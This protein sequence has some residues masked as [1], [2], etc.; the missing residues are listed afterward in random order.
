MLKLLHYLKPYFWQTILLLVV[1]VIRTWSALQLPALMADI[2]NH[3]IVQHDLT[4]VRQT[5]LLMLVYAALTAASGFGSSFL[6][7]RIGTSFARDLRADLFQKVLNLGIGEIEKFSTASLITRT[8]NDINQIQQAVIM[9][10]SLMLRVPLTCVIAVGLAVATAPSMTWIIALAVAIVVTIVICIFIVVGPKFKTLQKLVDKITLLTR[11]NLTGLRVVRA[12]NNQRLEK[13]KFDDANRE[14]TRTNIFVNK[15]LY[16]MNPMMAFM[17][18]AIQ[19]VMSFLM[20]SMLLIILPR[21]N[22]SAQRLNEVLHARPQIRWPRRTAGVPAKRPSVEFRKVSFAY[23]AAEAKV[24]HEISFVAQAGQTTARI[25]S[26]GSGKSTVINLVPRFL[27]V[28]SGEILVNG[29]NVKDYTE[30]DLMARIGYVP[31]RGKL[32]SGTIRE[33]IQFGAPG[34]TQQQVKLAAE[35]SQS[36]EFIQKLP[37]GYDARVASGGNNLSGGQ[38]QRLAIARAIAK[39]PDIYIF[40]DAFSAL[41]LKTDQKLRAAL[42]EVTADAVVLVVAQRISTIKHAEQIVVLDHGRVVG[43]GTH[44]ELLAGCQVYQEIARSQLSEAEY[45]AELKLSRKR[46]GGKEQKR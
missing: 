27:E 45:A 35:I 34:A 5:S 32:F 37:G 26:T 43:K 25:G 42:A 29:L 9:C 12:F 19:V 14:L 16:L 17:Q 30:D 41:D 39:N 36:A 46:G 2:V 4:Y 44:W 20:M 38:R 13:S 28:S 22:V 40:D 7:A 31:Q 24:L 8:T 18:Y 6:A 21:A 1:T 23:D 11:E 3:G 33:N 10:L 15:M